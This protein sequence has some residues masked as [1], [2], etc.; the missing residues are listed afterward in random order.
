MEDDPMCDSSPV[1]NDVNL[2]NSNQQF[3]DKPNCNNIQV[4]QT[5][6]TP[7][8]DNMDI[9][10]DSS[11]HYIDDMYNKYVVNQQAIVNLQDRLKRRDEFITYM[12]NSSTPAKKKLRQRQY[13]L[14]L[15][16][17]GKLNFMY[18]N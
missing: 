17:K 2:Y 11:E 3:V 12:I 14:L 13:E 4:S 5:G 7:D 8:L 18:F 10:G 6:L 9:E 15:N 1:I 16:D